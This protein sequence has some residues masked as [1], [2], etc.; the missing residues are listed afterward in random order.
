MEAI[1]YSRPKLYEAQRKFVDC[2]ARYT[3]VEASTKAG[4]TVACLVWLF[5]MAIKGKRGQHFWWIAPI[6]PQAHIAYERLKKWLNDS[7]L[8]RE[9]WRANETKQQIEIGG[10]YIDFKGADDP[11]S[12]YGE[13]VQAAVVDEASRCKETAWHALRSTLTAT[14]GP[15]KIIGNVRGRKNWAYQLARKAESGERDM[16][17]FK[18][19][20]Q[21]AVDGGIFSQAEIEDAKRMLPAG[22]FQELYLAE[23]SDDGGNPF[24]LKAINACRIDKQSI[25]PPVCYGIDLAKS[26]DWT[27]MIGLDRDG[28]EC[29]SNRWK[30]DWGQTRTR[31]IDD[32]GS[33]PTLVD[34]TG[35]GDPI[36]E[37]LCRAKMSIQGFKFSSNSKQQLM[38]GL[39][40]A[41]Q[42]GRVRFADELLINELETFEYEFTGRGVK[43]S[44]P[45]GLHDDGVCA[46][47]LAVRQMEE[48]K[49]AMDLN[50]SGMLAKAK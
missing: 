17:Y 49:Y 43:Y 12:L 38:E 42:Q 34:S 10:R 25:A 3:I 24:G 18:L 31:I 33:V 19:T 28:V 5:E 2:E 8:G 7:G 14:K 4:K 40:A 26:V 22:V 46:L 44:A 15:V 21:D 36:V 47:G 30:S 37:D 6:F 32:T 16:A 45:E 23:P 20:A 39:A 13:D 29:A 1:Q 27:W 41:I 11:D 35:V 50:F 9:V 48:P